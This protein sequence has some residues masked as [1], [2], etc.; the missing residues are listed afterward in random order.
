MDH[1]R[2]GEAAEILRMSVDTLRYYERIGLM[3]SVGRMASGI[4]RYTD[5]DIARLRFIQRAQLMNFSLA[6]IGELLEFRKNPRRSKKKVR[7]L[8]MDKLGEI[9]ARLASLKKLRAELGELVEAC[10]GSGNNC[11]IISG[12]EG[13]SSQR[14]VPGRRGQSSRQY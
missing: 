9:D 7:A 13:K 8:A 14:A 1:Y 6:A 2:I 10:P 5:E 3:P 4:R 11:A 12:I